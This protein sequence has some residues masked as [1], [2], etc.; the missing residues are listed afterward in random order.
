[1]RVVPGDV[2]ATRQGWSI[3]KLNRTMH[4]LG[5]NVGNNLLVIATR[6]D[7]AEDV[8]AACVLSPNFGPTWVNLDDRTNYVVR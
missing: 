7:E 5:G 3:S 1:V 6:Y 4:A 2:V 8:V